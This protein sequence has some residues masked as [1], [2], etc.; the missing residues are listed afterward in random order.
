MT[1][2][3][4]ARGQKSARRK[5]ARE[6][7]AEH[8]KFQV[9]Q[10]VAVEI[11]GRTRYGKVSEVAIQQTER[12]VY[13]IDVEGWE[14]ENRP[15]N[16]A[17]GFCWSHEADIRLARP[18]PQVALEHARR[19]FNEAVA[20]EDRYTGR[21]AKARAEI[22]DAVKQLAESPAYRVGDEM[23]ELIEGVAEASAFL[24]LVDWM[25]PMDGPGNLPG[26]ATRLQY[27]EVLANY[28]EQ[29]TSDI[30]NRDGYRHNSTRESS[31]ITNRAE[32]RALQE[33]RKFIAWQL[34]RLDT[35]LACE[36][37]IAEGRQEIPEPGQDGRPECPSVGL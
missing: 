29:Y 10:R 36:R 21:V 14:K 28:L 16:A 7:H 9:G 35:V 30:L 18:T 1:N 31:S 12:P 4:P 17:D 34:H 6:T 37:W 3:T 22:A 11:D 24:N 5:T 19:Q 2:V 23:A 25:K 20:S 13:R 26:I 27:R 15:D 33:A 32:F 8:P